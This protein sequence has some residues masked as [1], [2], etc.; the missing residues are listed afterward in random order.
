MLFVYATHIYSYLTLCFNS[1][2]LFQGLCWDSFKLEVTLIAHL[3][4]LV[5]PLSFSV[6]F[7]FR[8]WLLTLLD[9]SFY[10]LNFLKF[11][12]R[13][14][15]LK[16]INFLNFFV[17]VAAFPASNSLLVFAGSRQVKGICCPF[18]V[19]THTKDPPFDWV[20]TPNHFSLFLS[21][22]ASPKGVP[23]WLAF[24]FN[25]LFL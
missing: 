15:L 5:F 22:V 19:T 11:V 24:S 16:N 21:I 10:Y 6:I 17:C 7:I 3:N 9:R 18:S 8:F 4:F 2:R 12:C 25:F 13:K 20:T 1:C 23:K 14:F